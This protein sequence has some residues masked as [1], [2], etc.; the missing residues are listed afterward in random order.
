MLP[1]LAM[2]MQDPRADPDLRTH[3]HRLAHDLIVSDGLSHEMRNGRIEAQGLEYRHAQARP[4]G[5]I[6]ERR[7]TLG[8]KS[9][10]LCPQALLLWKI[11][12]QQIGCPEQQARRG[13]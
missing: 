1:E 12:R 8:R 11:K 2:A 3:L 10:D 7:Q 6:V 13:L 4:V 9:C 5:K